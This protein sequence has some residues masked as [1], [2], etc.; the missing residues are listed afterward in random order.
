MAAAI[1][2]VASVSTSSIWYTVQV[3]GSGAK[4]NMEFTPTFADSAATIE[5]AL[6]TALIAFCLAQF[7][8]EVDEGD[9][10]VLGAPY[11]LTPAA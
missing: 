5:D 10:L 2:T 6:L 3:V 11:K 1:V 7:A 8:I 9:I 4:K